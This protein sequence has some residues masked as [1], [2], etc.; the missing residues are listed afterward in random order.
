MKLTLLIENNRQLED[1]YS[2]NLQTWV[3]ATIE[4]CTTAEDASKR[5]EQTEVQLIIAK[6]RVGLERT[7]E[8]IWEY[9]QKSNKQIPLIVIGKSSLDT[10]VV[11]HLPTGLDIKALV[12]NSAR[13]LGVTAQDM[14]QLQV[15]EFY[16]I[17]IDYFK[18]LKRTET[19]IYEL[20]ASNQYELKLKEYEDFSEN[21]INN[22]IEN[23][24]QSLY[25][26]KQD[27]L[28]FVTNVTQEIL[29]QINLEELDDNE[30]IK[31]TESNHELLRKKLARVGI[32][33]E[34]VQ[35]AQKN[36]KSIMNTG[37]KFPRIKKLL[38]KLMAN[39]GSY[40]FK[41]IQILTFIGTQMLDHIDWGND[42]QKEKFAF[43]AYFHDILL[44]TDQQAIIRSNEELKSSNLTKEEK[45][46]VN[47]HAQKSAEL[48]SKY[49]HA[50][51]GVDT[52]IRQHH[53]V[54]HG[55]GFSETYGANLSPLAV[56]FILA[57]EFTQSIINSGQELNIKD[58]LKDLRQRYTTQRFQKIIDAFEKVAI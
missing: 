47:T 6:A 14:V 51:M 36:L 21:L 12:Q 48:V 10:A 7:A 27:R 33:E 8:V 29:A 19:N 5:I 16:N 52:I 55:L 22:Y 18:I 41:H 31:A 25:V 3:G 42:E 44:E 9:L 54:T 1:F 56:V 2:L 39:K 58:I 32:T 26:K 49:P 17:P 30:Q 23:G 11:T 40:V 53:G 38:A 43:I 13:L 35:L 15:P 37:K 34:T 24:V 57:E 45:D 46:L 50:P 4:K 20:S 28:K